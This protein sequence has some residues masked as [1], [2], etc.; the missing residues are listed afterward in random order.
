MPD[1][2]PLQLAFPASSLSSLISLIATELDSKPESIRL[3]YRDAQNKRMMLNG[4][5]R[6]QEALQ[7]L[8]GQVLQMTVVVMPE[9]GSP[10][11]LKLNRSAS[12]LQMVEKEPAIRKGSEL[13]SPDLAP[14]IEEALQRRTTSMLGQSQHYFSGKFRALLI[15]LSAASPSSIYEL[16][17]SQAQIGTYECMLVREIVELLPELRVLHMQGNS[18]GNSGVIQICDGLDK[19]RSIRYLD[20]SDNQLTGKG[21]RALAN[22]IGKIPAFEV[23]SL[24]RN[25]L[26]RTDL[27]ALQA[28]A[29]PGCRIHHDSSWSCGLM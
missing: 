29:S 25:K 1:R 9:Q 8:R 10:S 15:S 4:E 2:E 14:E 22:M 18:I 23:L 12:A 13:F 24:A 19:H 28:A 11:S 5:S 21:I 20:L 6:Y 3:T 26:E 27:E 17:L 7:A 16:E